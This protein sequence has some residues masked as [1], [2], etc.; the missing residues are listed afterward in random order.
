MT[1]LMA[2]S[3]HII[4]SATTDVQ[5][6]ICGPDKLLH[7]RRGCR[8]KPSSSANEIR[9]LIPRPYEKLDAAPRKHYTRGNG[10][11]TDAT[12]KKQNSTG[13]QKDVLSEPVLLEKVCPS[14]R[15]RT[16]PTD[17]QQTTHLTT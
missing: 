11:T 4:S 17:L 15:D 3:T 7:A 2:V 8:A 10:S 13:E 12:R 6:T 1:T 5:K 9:A 16:R 14:S